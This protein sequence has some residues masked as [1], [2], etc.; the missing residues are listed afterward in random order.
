MGTTGVENDLEKFS[1]NQLE[2]NFNTKVKKFRKM[3]EDFLIIIE[4]F[5]ETS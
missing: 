2:K 4:Q 5:W 1:L 3:F